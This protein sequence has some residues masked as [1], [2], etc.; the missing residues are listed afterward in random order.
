VQ[1][2]TLRE[3]QPR[4]REIF[5]YARGGTDLWEWEVPRRRR[6]GRTKPGTL[7]KH[8]IPLKPGHGDVRVPG[9]RPIDLVSNSGI[10]ASGD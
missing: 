5:L 3:F 4:P 1:R 9:F 6:Y 2:T 8:H 10:S 7:L